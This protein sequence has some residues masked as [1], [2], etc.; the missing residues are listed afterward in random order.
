MLG[1]KEVMAE[2]GSVNRWDG[3]THPLRAV[4]DDA[5]LSEGEPLPFHHQ[6]LLEVV[7]SDWQKH[8][9]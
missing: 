8:G 4:S 1:V 6:L 2:R 7:L 5:P 9:G 3:H